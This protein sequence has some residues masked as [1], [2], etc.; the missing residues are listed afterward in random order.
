MTDNRKILLALQYWEG[1]RRRAAEIAR[2]IANIEPAHSEVADFLFV[3]RQ[4]AKPQ[5][6][7]VIRHVSG[8]FNVHQHKATT[9]GVGHPW[10]CWVLW[11]E[12][13][14][15]LWQWKK[16]QRSP[17]YKAMLTFEADCVPLTKTWIRELSEEWDRVNRLRG[18]VN[19]MGSETWDF[20]DHV[21][22]NLFVGGN[23]DFLDYVIRGVSLKGCPM[24]RGW[25]CYLFPDF[26]RWG[27][28]NTVTMLNVCGRR[29]VE[30]DCLKR[31]VER[32]VR[33]IHGVKDDS[34]FSQA[35]AVLL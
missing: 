26:V 33:F 30:K 13:V 14:K 9:G 2:F 29:H 17:D 28:A 16:A 32:G 19:I 8:K 25:D 22:G 11:F 5:D 1:D 6:P 10:G 27:S 18:T 3:A 24:N 7:E 23:F 34:L 21:N 15:W 20:W 4:D 12:T 31:G 35:R